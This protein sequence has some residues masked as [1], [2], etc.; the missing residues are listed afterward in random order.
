LVV[1]FI[2]TPVPAMLRVKQPH[3]LLQ[4]CRRAARSPEDDLL[5]VEGVEEQV[6]ACSLR[7]GTHR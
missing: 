1:V 4:I 6:V 3:E 5:R 7:A 2:T